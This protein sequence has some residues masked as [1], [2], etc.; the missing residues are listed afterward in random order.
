MKL[1]DFAELAASDSKNI[2]TIIK[3]MAEAMEN[4][5]SRLSNIESAIRDLAGKV[6]NQGTTLSEIVGSVA[7]LKK[8]NTQMKEDVA[9][10]NVWT[11]DKTTATVA[12]VQQDD[13]ILVTESKK[14]KPKNDGMLPSK[15]NKQ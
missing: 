1:S 12:Q 6:G 2:P 10:L 13:M 5:N 7:T 4:T 3:M 9:I 8:D 15:R 14:Q 11:G